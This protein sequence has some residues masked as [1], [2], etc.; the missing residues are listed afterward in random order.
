MSNE[1]QYPLIESLQNP[2]LKTLYRLR[3][4]RAR[5]R[6]SRFLVEGYRELDRALS[7]NI[8]LA[9]LFICPELWS[10]AETTQQLLMTISEKQIPIFRLT[11]PAFK[12]VSVRQHPNG[13][14]AECKLNIQTLDNINI[15]PNMLIL[16]AEAIEKPGN[17]GALI[18]S[19]VAANAHAVVCTDVMT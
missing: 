17:L 1:Q 15:Q 10:D 16:V 6:Q 3:E 12:K 13:L 7:N 11:P 9:N 18:R 2:R 8:A 14:L 19:A 5:L 4:K